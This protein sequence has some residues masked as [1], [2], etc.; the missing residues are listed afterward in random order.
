MSKTLTEV[1]SENEKITLPR[2]GL[3]VNLT[4]LSEIDFPLLSIGTSVNTNH[5][6][7]QWVTTLGNLVLSEQEKSELPQVSEIR[8]YTEGSSRVLDPDEYDIEVVP[9]VDSTSFG[10]YS[11]KVTVKPK[12]ITF[13]GRKLGNIKDK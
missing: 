2:S 12:R 3:N 9:I 13:K 4:P 1:S 11:L 10:G 8:L 7:A 5:V 6:P